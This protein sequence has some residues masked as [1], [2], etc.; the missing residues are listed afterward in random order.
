[1]HGV[2]AP[3]GIADYGT[4][5][6]AEVPVPCTPQ[7]EVLEAT[8][9]ATSEDSV[10]GFLP[11]VLAPGLPALG[12]MAAPAGPCVDSRTAALG[13]VHV[14]PTVDPTRAIREELCG[15]AAR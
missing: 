11:N 5:S 12:F 2:T 13:I 7:A 9:G 8:C 1:M 4:L 15:P 3:E 6:E 14:A 10:R